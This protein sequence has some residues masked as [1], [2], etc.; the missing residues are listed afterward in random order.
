MKKILLCVFVLSSAWSFAQVK[1]GDNPNVIDANS[2]LELEGNDKVFVLTRITDAQMNALTP[3]AGALV[4]NT[5]FQCLYQFNGTSWEGLCDSGTDNQ[6]LSFNSVTNILTLENGGTVDLSSLINDAD[7]DATNEI[8]VITSINNTVSITQTGNDYDLS[9]TP[10]DD[11]TLQSQV[12]QNTDDIATNTANITTNTTNIATNASDI[13]TLEAE[14]T[15]QNTNISNNTAAINTHI[16]DDE[17]TD[18]ENELQNITS[19]DSSV[20]VNK[21]GNDYDL[22]VTPYDDSAL[23]SQVAQNT[24]DIAT[25]TAN[26]T[27]NTTNIATN[28]SDIDTLEA[29]Q[30]T[31]NTNISN[32][33]A[34]INAHI[35]DDE[36][37]DNENELQNITSTDS[38]VSVNKTGNDYDLS[39][40][41]YDDTALQSQ[42]AQNTADIATNTANITTNT[43]NI[44]TN[45]SDIDALEAEQATQNTNIANNAAA[46]A[47]NA[48]DFA[49]HEA[50]DLD[51]NSSNEIQTLS[52][53]GNDISLSNGGGSVTLPTADGSE[54][55][56]SAG[57]KI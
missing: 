20:S 41:P 30:T 34:A 29:E 40:T 54:T 37:T 4:Y 33:T 15:T 8:Q 9:V 25:N 21:T 53:S 18:N 2:I 17:D 45:A 47:T 42:V 55:A 46:I 19:T 50:A 7:S 12:A 52:I 6:Q 10:Y 49:D 44:A 5:D 24:A 35:T 13:D 14:Q 1:I 36:D 57:T 3:L 31:Q 48:T 11:T 43:T 38:S 32:N 27:T 22:S 28:A 39:V 51:M 26:I 16:T 56:V 23:Q